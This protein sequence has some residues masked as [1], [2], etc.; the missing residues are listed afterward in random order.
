M[1]NLAYRTLDDVRDPQGRKEFLRPEAKLE[2]VLFMTETMHQLTQE[3]RR[4]VRIESRYMR[5]KSRLSWMHLFAYSFFGLLALLLFTISAA[6][7]VDGIREGEWIFS[8]FTSVLGI[9]AGL[10][11][12]VEIFVG[13]LIDIGLL[14]KDLLLRQLGLSEG[15]TAN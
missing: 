13:F 11:L 1:E 9:I 14:P 5:Q 6:S 4:L 2:V 8:P 3:R 12:S 7:V 10:G 15:S